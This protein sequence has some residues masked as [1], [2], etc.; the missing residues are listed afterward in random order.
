[1]YY[2]LSFIALIIIEWALCMYCADAR[3]TRLVF[4]DA[5][6]RKVI[7]KKWEK[8][9]CIVVCIEMILFS[10]FR[11]LNVGADTVTYLDALAYYKSLPQ[12]K[13]LSAKLVYPFDFEI[14][15]FFLTKLCAYLNFSS[16]MFLLLIAAL[17]YIPLFIF[18]Y[19]NS[20]SSLLSVLIY[21]AFGLFSYSVGLFRQMIALSIC[22][23]AV[24]YIKKKKLIHYLWLCALASLFH[25]SALIMI[26]FYFFE[27]ID[28]K[29]HKTGFLILVIAIELFCFIFARK[30]IIK[31]LEIFTH[32]AGYENGKYDVQGGSYFHLLYLNLLLFLG[33]FIVSPRVDKSDTLC[34]KGIAIAC[35]I[36]SCAYAMGIMGRLVCYYSIYEILLIPLVAENGVKEKSIMKIMAIIVLFALLIWTLSRDN[37]IHNYT[38]LW[39]KTK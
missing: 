21:F 4:K 29:K 6:N 18:V 16:T 30:I 25:I 5:N 23:L 38:F 8:N 20:K 39:G 37:Y 7:E 27:Y 14:G 10:G 28:I 11:A 34:V 33:M 1:M 13:I 32:Y 36:Q 35:I 17:I 22:L 9:F 24:P 31:I 15:Y 19:K 3:A 12:E 2:I 26:P